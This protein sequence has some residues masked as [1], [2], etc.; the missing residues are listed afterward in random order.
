M[1]GNMSE[2]SAKPEQTDETRARQAKKGNKMAKNKSTSAAPGGAVETST[3]GLS[4]PALG[5]LGD[6]IK[7]R[8]AECEITDF[9]RQRLSRCLL[10]LRSIAEQMGHGWEVKPFGSAVNDFGTESSDL[11]VTCC[12]LDAVLGAAA[13]E[14][15]GDKFLPLMRAHPA[16][17]VEE[18]ILAARVPILKLRFEGQLEVD[19]SCN[20]LQPVRNT[21]LLKAYAELDLRVKELGLAVKLWAK[22]ADVCGSRWNLSSY[23]MTLLVIY[24]MQV[25]PEVQLPN[26]PVSAFEEGA[27]GTTDPGV[28]KAK[29]SW[30]CSLTVPDLLVRFFQFYATEF[31]WG[32]EVAAVRFGERRSSSDPVFQALR[33]RNASRLHIEDPYEFGRNLHG[34]IEESKLRKVFCEALSKVLSDLTPIGLCPSSNADSA[35]WTSEP[36]VS[37]GCT[38]SGWEAKAQSML[39]ESLLTHSHTKSVGSSSGST[40]ICSDDEIGKE[41]GGEERRFSEEEDAALGYMTPPKG[42]QKL[43]TDNTQK[44]WLRL[45]APEVK[46]EVHQQWHDDW[47]SPDKAKSWGDDRY[48]ANNEAAW[49]GG[50]QR[51]YA[52][53]TAQNSGVRHTPG[54]AARGRAGSG[55]QLYVD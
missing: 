43:P 4:F 9:G 37:E 5:H 3:G 26:L 7:Q 36:E 30:D 27:D 54:V 38:P 24:F 45:D 53:W 34:Y 55:R 25:H 39:R 32:K 14:V 29:N 28:L 23:A 44:W 49:R 42:D 20:N 50:G 22:A 6:D 52:G 13:A 8:L 17:V 46:Q 48:A 11:D 47:R 16:F 31:E 35:S 15:L 21:R 2:E 19:I 10:E 51:H 33:A 12:Q 18:K 40:G 1:P 41:S